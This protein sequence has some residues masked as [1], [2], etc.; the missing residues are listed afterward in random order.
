MSLVKGSI[1]N[2]VPALDNPGKVFA[3]IMDVMIR[4]ARCGLVHCD[5]NEFNMFIDDDDRI[6]I[7][8]FPQMISV[9]H[10][11]AAALFDRDTQCLRVF[12]ERRFGFIPSAVPSI[13]TDCANRLESLDNAV[14]AS[15]FDN[16]H[17]RRLE[18]GLAILG[19]DMAQKREKEASGAGGQGSSSDDDEGGADAEEDARESGAAC[20]VEYEAQAA[21]GEAGS[22]LSAGSSSDDGSVIGPGGCDEEP[23]CEGLQGCYGIISM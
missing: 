18:Q 7:I 4:L 14:K 21:T 10:P 3:R 1:L 19:V 13:A 17:Q 6:T 16:E 5:F 23:P 20:E 12:F 11:N 15:G 2:K 8:D 22:E 9:D